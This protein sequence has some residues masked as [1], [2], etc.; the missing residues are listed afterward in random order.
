MGD[1]VSDFPPIS[2]EGQIFESRDEII[3]FSLPTM[4]LNTPFAKFFHVWGTTFR[5]I[6]WHFLPNT[7]PFFESIRYFLDIAGFVELHDSE[8][9]AF[10]AMLVVDDGIVPIIIKCHYSNRH[11][12]TAPDFEACPIGTSEL[13]RYICVVIIGALTVLLCV[14][15]PGWTYVLA[16]SIDDLRM[17][18]RKHQ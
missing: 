6:G 10:F 15:F 1:G 7:C 4:A 16:D 11:Q 12:A 2:A 18:Q 9:V 5:L 8:A 17:K 14:V 3:A 13:A